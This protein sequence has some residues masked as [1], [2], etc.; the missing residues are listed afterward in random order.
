MPRGKRSVVDVDWPDFKMNELQL[1]KD[2]QALSERPPGEVPVGFNVKVWSRIRRREAYGLWKN[3][4]DRLLGTLARPQWATAA[5]VGV[6]ALGWGAARSLPVP[7]S[8]RRMVATITGEVI[9]MACYY[10][11]GASG[12]DHAACA[13]RCIESGLPVG[14]KANNGEIYVLIGPQLPPSPTP[15]PMHE[16]LNNQL[17]RYAAEI[18]TVR[19]IVV[20]KGGVTLV[21][22]AEVVATPAHG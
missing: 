18:V 4:F 21:E 11:V 10:D 9:D 17:A 1:N 22:N 3:W 14:L 20:Q 5:L 12:P 8:E 13:R 19:G 15:G 16:S 7:H 2:L 6:F